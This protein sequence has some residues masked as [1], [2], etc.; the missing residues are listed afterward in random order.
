MQAYHVEFSPARLQPLRISDAICAAIVPRPHVS[1]GD[2]TTPGKGIRIPLTSRLMGSIT[3][4]SRLISRAQAYREPRTGRI[5]LGVEPPGD[6]GDSGALVLLVA[7]SNFPEGFSVVPG[8]EVRLLANGEVP[9]GRQVLLIWPDGA[10]VAIDDPV[11]GERHEVRR[12]GDQFDR[13][14]FQEK[15]RP[16]GQ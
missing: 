2:P 4:E 13:I 8:R 3:Q 7:M 14:G 16:G 5:V 12:A 1:I 9:N 10:Q 11:R 15:S 6:A